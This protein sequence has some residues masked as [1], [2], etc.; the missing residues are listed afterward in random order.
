MNTQEA[1]SR[2][3]RMKDIIMN[4]AQDTARQIADAT[5]AQYR[6]EKNKILTREKERVLEEL[7]EKRKNQLRQKKM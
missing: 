2:I 1:A 6:I 7:K 3:E 4:E 5:D